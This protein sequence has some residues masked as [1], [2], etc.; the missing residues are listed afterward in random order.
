VHPYDS[1]GGDRV[2]L[3]N[4][5]AEVHG[6]MLDFLGPFQ[7]DGSGR[8]LFAKMRS[9]G[10][11]VDVAVVTRSVGDAWRRQYQSQRGIPLPP[12]APIVAGVLPRDVE[13]DR[14]VALPQG[15]Y[16]IVVDNSSVVGQVAPPAVTLFDPV[17]RV[18]YLI[19]MGDAP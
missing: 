11:P 6:N 18:S 15:E 19:S 14:S 16:Y 10:L 1:H 8:M 13:I 3:L 17:A 5:L 2:V 7:V 12:S 9:A 4:E